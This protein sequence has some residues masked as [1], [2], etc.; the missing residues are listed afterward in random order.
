MPPE[1]LTFTRPA[2]AR[3]M[4]DTASA[5]APPDAKPVEVLTNAAPASTAASTARSICGSVSSLVSR[6]TFTGTPAG[7]VTAVTAAISAVT[8]SHKPERMAP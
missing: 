6:I 1:A 8:R 7:A 2:A 5:V 4:A 3:T